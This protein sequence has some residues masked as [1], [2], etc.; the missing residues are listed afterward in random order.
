MGISD[1]DVGSHKRS[2]I[3]DLLLLGCTLLSVLLAPGY[4]T[5]STVTD[6]VLIVSLSL[7]VGTLSRHAQRLLIIGAALATIGVAVNPL[8]I[9]VAVAAA[10]LGVLVPERS[11]WSHLARGVSGL[12]LLNV[13]LRAEY[14]AHLGVSAA[15]GA[16]V[17]IVL[18]ARS[19]R[20]ARRRRPRVIFA[21]GSAL[22]IALFVAV[23]GLFFSVRSSE[24]HLRTGN[25][26]ARAG[27]AALNVGD[28]ELARG[29]LYQA[30][31]SMKEATR[32]LDSWSTQPS[33]LLPVVALYRNTIVEVAISTTNALEK[34]NADL[35]RVDPELLR[36]TNGWFDVAAISDLQAPMGRIVD[37]LLD[38]QSTV[39][40][41]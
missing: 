24:A 21:T 26:E 18:T 29:H 2:R 9:G 31:A 23:A 1:E 8:L 40:E 3:P 6:L 34:I 25:R 19:L 28:V 30:L 33:R 39:M 4:P 32:Q 7:F 35:G 10:L 22:V 37:T 15:V 20:I 12:G 27:L 14:D 41:L 38:L 16:F 36:P 13:I 11:R 5:G 17:V